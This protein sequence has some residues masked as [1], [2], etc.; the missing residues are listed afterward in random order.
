MH[1]HYI[2]PAKSQNVPVNDTEKM[3]LELIKTMLE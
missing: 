2:D 3:V 1:V